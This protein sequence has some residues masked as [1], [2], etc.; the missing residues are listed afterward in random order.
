[1]TIECFKIDFVLSLTLYHDAGQWWILC[2][3]IDKI[4][5]FES[6]LALV[7]LLLFI[8]FLSVVT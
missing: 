3:P 5:L 8:Y 1:M 2:T 4:I 7:V 6:S